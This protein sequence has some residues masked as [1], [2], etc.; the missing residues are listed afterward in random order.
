M[1]FLQCR[2]I[3]RNINRA[4]QGREEGREKSL[5]AASKRP[6]LPNLCVRL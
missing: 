3:L 4:K 5:D 6:L 1:I 2:D